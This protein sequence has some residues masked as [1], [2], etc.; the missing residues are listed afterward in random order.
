MNGDLSDKYPSQLLVNV[1]RVIA[2]VVSKTLWFIRYHGLNNIPDRS[3]CGFVIAANHQTYLDPAWICPPIINRRFRFMAYDEAFKWRV[4][5]PFIKYLGAFP[6]SGHLGD[7]LDAV[8]EALDSL[9]EGS[10]LIIF[11]EGEREF[12]DGKILPF[13]PGAIRIALEAGV[14][15]LPVTVR[16]GNRVWPQTQK[17]PRLFRRVEIT[18]HPPIHVIENP[19][20][21]PHEEMIKYTDLLQ[22][23]IADV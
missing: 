22:A 16:G 13:K 12:P 6:V 5:G 18:Y 3:S 14:P 23:V 17:L 9:Q 10:V 2:Y 4:I 8:R 15:I 11:P 20:K 19:D 21:N 7:A 1:L